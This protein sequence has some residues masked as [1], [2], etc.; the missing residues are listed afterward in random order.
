MLW[1]RGTNQHTLRVRDDY[2]L[3]KCLTFQL[4]TISKNNFG[5]ATLN[6]ARLGF[7]F[8]NRTSDR[9]HGSRNPKFLRQRCNIVLV[10]DKHY[11]KYTVSSFNNIVVRRVVVLREWNKLLLSTVIKAI[12]ILFRKSIQRKYWKLIKIK[13]INKNLK[14]AQIIIKKKIKINKF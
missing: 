10:R 2:W 3:N 11:R 8:N 13:A 4:F 9:R 14:R 12:S 5:F 1:N 6:L 7:R